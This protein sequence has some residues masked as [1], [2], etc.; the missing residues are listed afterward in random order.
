MSTH[1]R[2]KWESNL[3]SSHERSTALPLHHRYTDDDVE[4]ANSADSQKGSCVDLTSRFQANEQRSTRGRLKSQF[5]LSQ[6]P[7]SAY[8]PRPY[9]YTYLPSQLADALLD[10]SRLF[11]SCNTKC[12]RVIVC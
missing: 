9:L 8:K 1:G 2:A 6:P 5:P 4:R 7:W 11:S 10:L 12:V 3:R